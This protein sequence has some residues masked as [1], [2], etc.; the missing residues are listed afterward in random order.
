[1]P[2]AEPTILFKEQKATESLPHS[3][4]GFERQT[5]MKQINLSE[6]TMINYFTEV[7]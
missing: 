7:L 4:Y 6:F 2:R 3:P 1:M 5:F